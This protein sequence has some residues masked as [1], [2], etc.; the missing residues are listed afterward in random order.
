MRI[1]AVAGR[2]VDRRSHGETQA[3]LIRNSETNQYPD[4]RR[5][6]IVPKLRRR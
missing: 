1:S 2:G 3:S 6:R 5:W 4:A